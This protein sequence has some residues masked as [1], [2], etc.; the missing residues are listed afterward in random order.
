MNLSRREV[1]AA[2]GTVAAGSAAASAT[3]LL[4]PSPAFAASA[5]GDVVGKITVGY[6]GWFACIGDGAPINGW[7]HWSQNW[8]QPPSPANNAIKAWPD[9]REY[10]KSYQTSYANLNNG[11][12]ATLF[13]SYD[14]S[15]VNLHFLWMQQNGCDTAALQRFNPNTSEG[16]TRDAMAAKVRAAA[17]AYGRK[18]YIMY[19][20]TGWTAMQSEIKTDWTTKMSAH[21]ASPAYARQNGKPVVC[22]WGF[23]FSDGNHPWDAAT[24]LD[25]VNWFRSQGCYVIGGVP[26]E[27]R[28]GTGGSR[29][30]YLGV[31]H[32]FNMLSPWMV[33]AIGTAADSDNAY[34]AYTVPDQAD[35]NANGVDYQPCVL[36]GDVSANQR[37]HGDFMWRQFY[38]M[39]RAGVQGIYISMFDEYG[40]GNQIAKTAETQ[41]AVPAGS[42]LLTLDQDGTACSSDYYLRLTNDGGRMLKGQ[43]ALTATRPTQPVLGSGLVGTVI[44]LRAMAN[45]MIVTADNAGASPLIA[46]RT[47]IGAWEEFDL[48][49]AGNGNIALR[50]HANNMI[51]TAENAGASPLIANRTAIGQWESFQLIQNSNGT[52][53]LRALANT[54][55]VTADNAGASPLIANRTAIG[56]WEEFT[57]IPD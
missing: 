56:A 4:L 12:P 22:I 41:A 35:C 47:A 3:T 45:T 6:Q 2:V 8:S 25:V 16:P 18:F 17:E 54:M 33:G 31:Y 34:Q 15:S 37:A 26:R 51:V 11:S 28:T 46:N 20:V 50:A 57:L 24:C 13:S 53:S 49:D 55:I 10:A 14:Q 21:T 52:I 23:G 36:P 38:N 42:G 30:G 43:I 48:L 1:L 5:A 19:D 40:E 32:A 44:S 39:V 27:W 7:W 9:M 29:S